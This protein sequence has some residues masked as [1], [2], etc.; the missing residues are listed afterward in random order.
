MATT[1]AYIASLC[2]RKY[3]SSA[4]AKNDVACQEFY[5]SSYNYVGIISFPGLNL[6][7]KVITEIWLYIDSEKAGYGVK[8][9]KTVYLRKANYQDDIVSGV[10]GGQYVGDELGTFEGAFYGNYN[11]YHITGPLFDAMAAYISAGNNSFTIYN[12]LA[13]ASPHGYSYNYMQW[14]SV[15]I[16]ITFEDVISLPTVSAASAS[17]GSALTISTNRSNNAATHTLSY[18]FGNASGLIGSD[19]G[20][21][22]SWTPPLS[23]ASEIP[24]AT[25]GVCTITCNSFI[26]GKMTG[27]RTCT[28]T[29]TVPSTVAPS[30]SSVILQDTNETVAAK[31]G[32]FV[33]SLST[34]SVAITAEGVYGSCISSYRTMLD[35]ATYTAASFTAGKKLSAAGDMTLT[36]S[37]T[38]SRGRTAT[39][40]T[41]F[42]VLDYAVPSIRQFSVERCNAD[43]SSAQVDGTKARFSFQGSV[44]PLNNKNSFS[45]VVYYK[46]KNAEAWTQ[47]YAVNAAS[48]TLAVSNQLLSQ[49][50]DALSS[51]DVKI[52]LADYFQ[53]VEQA[54]SI[55]TKGV[56]LDFLADGTGIGIGKVAE[57]PGAIECGWPLKLSEPLDIAYGGTGAASAENALAALGGVKKAGDTMTGNLN[58]SGYLYPSMLLLPTYNDTT[59]RT[60]F[61]GSYAGA[62]SFAAWEDSTGNN[63]RMLEVRTKAY[64]NSLDWAIVL[65]VCEAGVWNNYRVFHSGMP[66]GVP[67][68]NGGTGAAN[69]A[70]ARKN[71]GA[72]N[73]GNLTTGTLPSARLPFK[74]AYGSTTINGSSAAY[75]D[76]SA[77]GFTSVPVVLITYATTSGNWSG[78]NGAIKVYNKTTTSCQVIA[79]G[80]FNT[81]R[82]VD[83]F[84]FGT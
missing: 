63:R 20:D 35:G 44:S 61:E 55:G 43:G 84:A 28:V 78:D 52:R 32:A 67:V 23:L 10:T 47:A 64:Q 50:Y 38:D 36:V 22:V 12:P 72:N 18:R 30:I 13:T 69:A 54:V 31:I 19:V 57:T 37:V 6:A 77:A 83:W 60:V 21:V 15:V 71:L 26:N 4:N 1:L 17:L 39:Y 33:K 68:A 24:S 3:T 58:I 9:T 73:A 16:T 46:L 7:N 2:T 11:G 59:N 66:S 49:T 56:I 75:V 80:N 29:L 76:Y 25:S 42:Q 74:F 82:A 5:D 81:S 14:A 51:Y 41:V 40:T 27:S 70:D 79:G 53:K 48:Y 45:C 34:L 62:S 65:R 8:N